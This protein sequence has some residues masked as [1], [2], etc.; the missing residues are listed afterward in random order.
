[1][2]SELNVTHV[3]CV[4]LVFDICVQSSALH[5]A[6]MGFHTSVIE[7]CTKPLIPDDVD[8]VKEKLQLG[9]VKVISTEEALEDLDA[10]GDLT[11]EDWMQSSRLW[12]QAKRTHSTLSLGAQPRFHGNL[13]GA[14]PS[15]ATEQ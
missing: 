4:G 6:E 12:S 8:S 5:G 15:A 14:L 9:G 13:S 2:L 1:M 10:G 3:Y 11:F 7:D